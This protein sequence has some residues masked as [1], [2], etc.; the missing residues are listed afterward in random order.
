[1]EQKFSISK[2]P[3]ATKINKKLDTLKE[4][5]IYSINP[6][7]LKEIEAEYFDKK[8]AKSKEMVTEAMNNMKKC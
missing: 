4:M 6:D 1:M 8:C 7:V 2:Y 5:P 3:D